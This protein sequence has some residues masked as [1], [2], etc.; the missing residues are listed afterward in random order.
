MGVKRKNKKNVAVHIKNP[1]K[2]G[3]SYLLRDEAV[4]NGA[5]GALILKYNKKNSQKKHPKSKNQ[6]KQLLFFKRF[7]RKYTGSTI[8]NISLLTPISS[9]QTYRFS[10]IWSGSVW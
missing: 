9:Q 2:I 3:K 7:I 6:R 10:D 4:K 5:E 8:L 1:N